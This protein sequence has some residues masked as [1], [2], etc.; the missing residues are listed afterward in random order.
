MLSIS[1]AQQ[2]KRICQS[3]E[4]QKKGRDARPITLG[5]GKHWICSIA[6][7]FNSMLIKS[8]V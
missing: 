1:T 8:C 3:S 7:C 2:V 5:N 6:I 4:K